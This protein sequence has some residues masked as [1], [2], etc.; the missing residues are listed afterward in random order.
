[1]NRTLNTFI[2]VASLTFSHLLCPEVSGADINF[3]IRAGLNIGGTSPVPIPVE[4]RGIK[5]FNPLLLPAV[6]AG[7]SLTLSEEWGIRTALCY[8]HKGMWTSAVVKNYGMQLS[9]GDGNS[10]AGF[11]TGRVDTKVRNSFITLPICAIYR[12]GQRWSFEAGPYFSL[13]MRGGFSGKVYEGYLRNGTPTG[14]KISFT[15]GVSSGYDFSDQ[16]RKFHYGL[17]IG[18]GYE[19]SRHIAASACL[20]CGLNHV[21]LRSFET[22]SFSMF[23][24]YGKL[25]IGYT[26]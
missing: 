17:R 20:D 7:A 19:I 11:W 25:C 10:I 8:E 16:Y 5:G 3:D 24:I 23:P 1:M 18:A 14:D 21:F 9:G 6:E 4:I 26:F 15:D 22:V 2:L 12:A 13:L